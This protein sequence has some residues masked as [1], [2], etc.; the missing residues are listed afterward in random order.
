MRIDEISA[1]SGKSTRDERLSIVKTSSSGKST[2]NHM[3][4]H[5][6]AGFGPGS[7]KVGKVQ[8]AYET[9]NTR[10]ESDWKRQLIE[11]DIRL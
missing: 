4:R 6:T 10:Q 5:S 8:G 1:V 11:H 2:G 9:A 3:V 7:V